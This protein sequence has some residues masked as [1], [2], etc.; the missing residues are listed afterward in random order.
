MSEKEVQREAQAAGTENPVVFVSIPRQQAE[1]LKRNLAQFAAAEYVMRTKGSTVQTSPEGV[2]A[3]KGMD[4]RLAEYGRNIGAIMEGLVN[5]AKVYQGGGSEVIGTHLSE[6]VQ[7]ASEAAVV[8]LYPEFDTADHDKWDR[9]IKR[10]KDGSNDPLSV[11][12]YA[13]ETKDHP[14]AYKVMQ[15]IG[16]SGKRGSEVRQHFSGA[17]YGWPQDAIDGSLYA[18]L[19]ADLISASLNGSPKLAKTLTK[20]DISSS[21]FKAQHVVLSTMTAR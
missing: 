7:R 6:A 5:S 21:V 14:A 3:K 1:D 8:R 2:E 4:N 11:V 12:D 16:G 13:G 19:A 10:A 18:L 9:V 15:F 17:P 20:P